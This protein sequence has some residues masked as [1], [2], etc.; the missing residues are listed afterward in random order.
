MQSMYREMTELRCE[1]RLREDNYRR[2]TKLKF[3]LLT[4]INSCVERGVS[5]CSAVISMRVLTELQAWIM[6]LVDWW[7]MHCRLQLQESSSPWKELYVCD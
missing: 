6:G 3:G 7:R 4:K 2:D 5:L 1:F